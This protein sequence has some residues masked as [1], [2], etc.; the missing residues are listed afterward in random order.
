MSSSCP[1]PISRFCLPSR[2]EFVP[3]LNRDCDQDGSGLGTY[4]FNGW[5]GLRFAVLLGLAVSLISC[6]GESSIASAA[7]PID[8]QRDIQPLLKARCYSCH[9][10]AKQTAAYRLD[11]R[12]RAI[13]GGES[14]QVAIVPGKPDDSDLYLRIVSTD[15]QER[16]PPKGDPLTADEIARVRTWIQE[17]GRWP[18]ALAG[19]DQAASRHW[20]F[21]P[22]VRPTVPEVMNSTWP[23]NEIDRFVL[24]KMTPAGLSPNPEADRETL[25][26]RLSLDL[27]GLPP[28]PEEVD[29]FVSNADPKAYEQLVDRLLASPHFGERWGR[30]WLDAARYADSDGFEKDKPRFVWMYRQWVIDALNQDLPYDQFIIQQ[31]AGDLLPNATQDQIVATGFLRNSMINEEG[32]VDPEQFRMEAM[33]DRMDAIGKGVLGLTIQCAQCHDHKY[34]P[35]TQI[36]YY[37]MFACLN[38]SYEASVAVYPPEQLKLRSDLLR[39]IGEREDQIRQQWPDWPERMAAWEESVRKPQTEWQIVRPEE[40][41]SGGQKHYVLQDGSILAQGYAPTKHETRFPAKTNQTSVASVRLELLNDPNLPLGGPGRSIFGLG[42][43][44]EFKLEVGPAD[45][46]APPKEVKIVS[47]TADVNPPERPLE[48]NFFDKTDRKRI[49]GP[50]QFAIDRV[51]ETGWSIDLG[52]GRSN[53]PRQAVFVLE[54]PFEHPSGVALI[55]RLTQ[56]HGGWNSDDNQ[57]NN[58][59]RFRFAVSD[60]RTAVADPVPAS[61]REIFEIPREQRTEAQTKTVFR[62]WRETFPEAKAINEQIEQLWQKH[63]QATSQLVLTERGEPRMTHLLKRG[64]FLKPAQP[65]SPGMASL[66][67]GPKPEETNDRLALARGMVRRESPTTSRAAVNRVWQTLFGTGIVSTSEDLGM[68][69]DPPTHPELLDWLAVEFM[70]GGW[71]TKSLLRQIVLSA[72]YRQSSVVSPEKRAIDPDNRLLARAS[73]FRLEAELVRD[74][75]LASSGLLNPTVGGPSVHPPLPEFMTQPPASYGPKVWKEDTGPDRYRRALYTFRFRSIPYPALQAFDAP[76]GDF[77]CVRRSRSNT[78][79]QALMTLNEP[80][81]VEAAQGLALRTVAR[82]KQSDEQRLAY[83][84]RCCVSR[85]PQ[86][87]EQAELLRLLQE[88]RQRFQKEGA[89]LPERSKLGREA[90]PD[91]PAGTTAADFAAWTVVSRVLLNLDETISRP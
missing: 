27:I 72:T 21:R 64:D 10:A 16:M 87:E 44:T 34:D 50:I 74:L 47:A 67:Q 32:G 55:F 66:L 40:D 18:D 1:P 52:P 80:I 12:S 59:G 2:S 24:A 65:V 11:I 70:D 73:R 39:E 28:T 91:L 48:A 85:T 36:D 46:S 43:L 35:L 14:G 31:L 8:F 7:E 88:Q 6:G 13:K 69:C 19:D 9:D 81:F 54:Q 82:E 3:A 29:A 23:R 51:D 84:F 26:R 17:G 77:A 86:P 33:F 57:N 45:G 5:S 30:L 20:A 63:P 38:N 71:K 58:L 53:Q 79:L 49:T 60:S 90:V 56:N 83:A 25:I 42:V 22:P 62:A 89:V 75:F 41:R 68:Q 76:N 37:R 78:P 4:R 15:P 61:V